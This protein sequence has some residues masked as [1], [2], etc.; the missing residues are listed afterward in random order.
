MILTFRSA[1]TVL[2]ALSASQVAPAQVTNEAEPLIANGSGV[3]PTQ[4]V[5]QPIE[6]SAELPQT[7][8]DPLLPVAEQPEVPTTETAEP[9]FDAGASLAEKVAALRGS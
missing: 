9:A 4:V 5:L 7:L 8:D 1:L 3:M 2:A 6:A